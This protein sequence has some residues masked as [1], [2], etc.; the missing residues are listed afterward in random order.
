M[1]SIH[2]MSVAA[3]LLGGAALLFPLTVEAGS[4]CGGGSATALSVPEYGR[5]VVDLS[6]DYERYDGYWNGDGRHIPDPPGSDL[7]QYRATLGLG[8]RLGADWQASISLPYVWNDNNYAGLASRTD[9]LGDTTVSLLYELL[10]DT[11]I[12]KVREAGDLVP[13]VTVGA[14][15]LLPT[16]VSPYDDVTSSF[17]VTGRGFYRLDGTLTVEKTL[18]PWNCSLGL[19]YGRYLER[20]VNREYGK[21]VTPY[22]KQ[23]GDRFGA[24]LS[25]GYT[26]VVGT[27]GDSLALSASYAYLTEDDTRYDGNADRGS[28]FDKQ[29]IGA[30]LAYASTDHDWSVRLGWNHALQ[31][32][33]WGENFPTTDIYSLG[34]RYVFR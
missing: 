33:G 12:W 24:N 23:L 3:A 7:N 11:A 6:F 28:G 15:L 4:C 20:P 17:D 25:A 8:Y 34:V 14:S 1:R 10:D 18:R 13:G 27:G 19:S 32:N 9:D 2:L 22:H 26:L 21:Y 29:A 5:A 31:Q 30:A 16:G